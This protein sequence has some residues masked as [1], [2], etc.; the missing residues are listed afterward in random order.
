MDKDQKKRALFQHHLPMLL[1][2]FSLMIAS[3]QNMIKVPNHI[4]T[5]DGAKIKRKLRSNNVKN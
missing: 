4:S 1:D 3:I 2:T 5:K